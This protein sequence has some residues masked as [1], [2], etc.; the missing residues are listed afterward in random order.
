MDS[1][2]TVCCIQWGIRKANIQNC[3]TKETLCGWSVC[4]LSG[5]RE[6]KL[7]QKGW[8][9]NSSH[10][11]RKFEKTPNQIANAC[12]SI[13]R[14]KTRSS[15]FRLPADSLSLC[16]WNRAEGEG[17]TQR[18]THV[19][20]T[21]S[22][23]RDKT[24]CTGTSCHKK[25]KKNGILFFVMSGDRIHW[26]IEAVAAGIL[27]YSL[28]E[29]KF[30]A[31]KGKICYFFSSRTKRR[32]SRT[33][34]MYKFSHCVR[35]CMQSEWKMISSYNGLNALLYCF[36]MWAIIANTSSTSFD[37]NEWRMEWKE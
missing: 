25:S 6:R 14:R 24:A 8:E 10:K 37:R 19:W 9:K 30:E 7:E 28:L 11:K 3:V 34:Q 21:H 13:W 33:S 18:K 23:L 22:S 12:L 36:I 5:S 35:M 17:E 32:K 26:I 15:D 31:W 2:Y 20:M 1:S 16:V 4:M 27:S 29:Q